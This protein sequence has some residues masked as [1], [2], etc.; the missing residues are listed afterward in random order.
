ML[1]EQQIKDNK[2]KFLQLVSEITLEEADTQGLVDFLM[3]SDFFEAPASTKFHCNFKGGLCLHSLNVYT[4]LCDLV[5]IY[6]KGKYFDDT[7]KIVSL[8]HD[9]SKTNFYEVTFRN[10]NTGKKDSYGKDIWV[11]EPSYKVREADNR[12]L[13]TNHA[14]I[15]F[16]IIF[17]FKNIC[18]YLVCH[19]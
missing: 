9:I 15:L 6:A 8:F 7:L 5:N 13:A 1:T 17:T 12:F 16:I 10:V 18:T 2:N 14:T 4:V 3:G 11:K 19:T